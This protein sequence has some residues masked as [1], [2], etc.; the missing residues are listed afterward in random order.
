MGSALDFGTVGP[1]V[2]NYGFRPA[3]PRAPMNLPAMSDASFAVPRTEGIYQFVS[4]TPSFNVNTVPNWYFQRYVRFRQRTAGEPEAVRHLLGVVDGRRLFCTK[5]IMHLTVQEFLD[6]ADGFERC[7][8]TKHSYDGDRLVVAVNT[9]DDAYVS[10]I[11]NWDEGWEAELDGQPVP[12]ELLF[13]TFKSVR[14]PAG[15]QTLVFVY[16]PHLFEFAARLW[17]RK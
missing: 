16:R 8:V 11:D 2:W 7:R 5:S 13:G 1:F 9:P 6:D 15:R 3:M 4:M 12:I 17:S 14:V 10:F